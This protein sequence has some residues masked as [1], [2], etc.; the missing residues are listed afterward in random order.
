MYD[1]EGRIDEMEESLRQAHIER[2]NK[3]LCHP[4]AGILFLDIISNLERV[5]DHC[6]NIADVV[7]KHKYIH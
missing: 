1:Y 3:K 5:A 4:T 7:S 6:N 2:L